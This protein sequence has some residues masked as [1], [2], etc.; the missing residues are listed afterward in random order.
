MMHAHYQTK[1]ALK[2]AVGQTLDY[3][4]TSFFGAEYRDNGSFPVTNV[5]RSWFANVTMAN[6]LIAK[7][8]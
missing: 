8:E 4:E 1:K 7:V 2:A 6:G 5:K 3:S